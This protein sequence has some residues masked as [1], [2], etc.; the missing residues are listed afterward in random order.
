MPLPNQT[1]WAVAKRYANAGNRLKMR[2][3]PVVSGV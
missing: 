1:I 3:M 2:L